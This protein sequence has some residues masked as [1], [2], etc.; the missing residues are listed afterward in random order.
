V[1]AGEWLRESECDKASSTTSLQFAC[2]EMF[3]NA[4]CKELIADANVVS[5]AIAYIL[6]AAFR[7]TPLFVHTH[8]RTPPTAIQNNASSLLHSP[9]A[10]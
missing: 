10:Q 4:I 5:V 3:A 9:R 1:C 6:G 7:T 8:I 2:A